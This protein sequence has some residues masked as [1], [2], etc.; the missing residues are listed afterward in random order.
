MLYTMLDVKLCNYLP[1]LGAMR[2]GDVFLTASDDIVRLFLTIPTRHSLNFT[3]C[4]AGVLPIGRARFPAGDIGSGIRVSS[5]KRSGV[6][7]LA[8]ASFNAGHR[9]R[10]NYF[11]QI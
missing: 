5:R 3:H 1:F 10:Y 8:G 4:F 6:P 2:P 9:H 7:V 11:P